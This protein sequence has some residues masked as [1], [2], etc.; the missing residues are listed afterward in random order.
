MKFLSFSLL[1]SQMYFRGLFFS[2]NGGAVRQ[3]LFQEIFFFKIKFL[4]YS[5]MIVI[6]NRFFLYFYLIMFDF[7]Y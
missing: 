6:K 7:V 2:L 3:P 5:R 1:C 4:I